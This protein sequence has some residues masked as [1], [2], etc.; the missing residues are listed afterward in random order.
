MA[1]HLRSQ[2]LEK[3]DALLQTGGEGLTQAVAAIE[4]MQTDYEAWSVDLGDVLGNASLASQQLKLATIEIRR[5]PW[6]LLYR[7]T[8]DELEHE[9]LYEAARSFAVAAADLKAASESTQRMLDRHGERLSGD[10][11][12]LDRVRSNLLEPLDR[13]ESAQQ[14]L[15]DVLISE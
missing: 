3:V 8:P 2:T 9:L 12:L 10:E 15:F 11:E 14:R 7:P 4:R 5:S 1:G 13:Y 6:K